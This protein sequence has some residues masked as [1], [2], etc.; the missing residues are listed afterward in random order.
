MTCLS[1]PSGMADV[2]S[3][4]QVRCFM[5]CQARW[6]FKYRLRYQDPATGKLALGR[7]VHVAL[8][9]N[10]EQ[11]IDT[12]EDL[13]TPGVIA[14]F[15]EAW[16]E[17]RE[18]TEFRDDEDPSELAACGEILVAKYLDEVAP[19]IE[20]AA[21]E[22]RVEGEIGGVTVQGWVDL[23]DVNGRIL[24]LKTAARKPSSIAPE[25]RFQI[26]TYVQLTPGANGEARLDTLV[27][28]KRPAL[29][30]QSFTITEQ[31]VLATRALYP[32]AQ[33]IMQSERCMPNRLSMMC[34]RRNCSFWRCCQ[35]EWGG[36]VP[37]S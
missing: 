22:V 30:T 16:A 21:V 29:V 7:A 27:K 1:A 9:R 6:W 23:L 34:S 15:R 32:L 20:P 31:D 14:I 36:E 12:Y 17:E 18:Q 4:S 33:T 24:D 2:L 5:D 37:E 3:A 19:M 35:Q 26:A 10:F 25:H 11:K 13:P 28:T 8:A